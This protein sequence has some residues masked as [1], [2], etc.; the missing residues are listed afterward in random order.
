M[1]ESYY[2]IG[3]ISFFVFIVALACLIENV[4]I[5]FDFMGTFVTSFLG[6]LFPAIA[7]LSAVSYY[8]KG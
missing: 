8:R 5:V 3:T 6:F 1:N 2:Y 7:Y 4:D